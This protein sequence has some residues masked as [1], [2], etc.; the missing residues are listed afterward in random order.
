MSIDSTIYNSKEIIKKE[1]WGIC[2]AD[3]G[4]VQKVGIEYIVSQRGTIDSDKFY[5]PKN[6]HFLLFVL[7]YL[8]LKINVLVYWITLN[9]SR[10]IVD[11]LTHSAWLFMFYMF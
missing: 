10:Y 8:I 6:S 9:D 3:L 4:Q 1:I 5:I 7:S 2:D 11:W